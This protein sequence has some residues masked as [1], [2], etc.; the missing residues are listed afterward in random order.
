[1]MIKK[2][3]I[4][5]LVAA[6]CAPIL[7]AE[8]LKNAP[9]TA[10]IIG[11]LREKFVDGDRLDDPT[12]DAA[13][14]RGILEE[15]GA[16]AKWISAETNAAATLIATNAPITRAEIIEPNIAYVHIGDVDAGAASALD[17]QW[18][19]FEVPLAKWEGIVLD[20]R[21]ADG[22][23]YEAAAEIA[24]RFL[25]EPAPLFEIKNAKGV[26]RS[27][28]AAQAPADA[29]KL[30]DV[31]L[32]LLVNNQTR[33][34]AEALAA[35]L[36]QQ[37]RGILIGANTSGDAVAWTDVALKSGE[38]LRIA[39]AKVVLPDGSSPF[40]RGVAA[41]VKVKIDPAVERELIFNPEPNLTL[42]AS[43]LP[44]EIRKG[45][46]EADLVR[47]FTPFS[48]LN[49]VE[50]AKDETE[51]QPDDEN[52]APQHV[53]EVKDVVLQRAVDILKGIRVLRSSL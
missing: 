8:P 38:T 19:N 1:M 31:P 23:N 53:Q 44:K 16:G 32:M 10:E 49:A 20:L 9:K 37:T 30:A 13:A 28:F 12:L 7:A 43:L 26:V 5:V 40:P 45:P 46:S 18:Q 35:V 34:A 47:S 42:T 50:E 48:P 17:A 52:A 14:A 3:T 36:R 2:W 4:C 33:G 24:A 25:S 11:I 6:I 22:T 41:D 39:T 51:K 21:F 15:I 27:K 29:P